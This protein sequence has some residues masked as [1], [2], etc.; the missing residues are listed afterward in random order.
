VG[1]VI[2]FKARDVAADKKA[3]ATLSD[4]DQSTLIEKGMP[5]EKIEGL[6]RWMF[7]ATKA[8][9]A[10]ITSYERPIRSGNRALDR[11]VLET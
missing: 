7:T 2:R 4:G 9:Q 6:S 10:G 3:I 1:N 8:V 11:P 5:V